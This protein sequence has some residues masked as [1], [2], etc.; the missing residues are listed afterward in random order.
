MTVKEETIDDARAAVALAAQ[1]PEIDGKRI[2]V[3]GHSLGGYLAP[4]IA[5]G[6]AQVTGLIILAGNTRPMEDLI[7]EQL[8]AQAAATPKPPE[9]LTKAIAAAEATKRE[10]EDP[11]LKAGT[12]VKVLGMDVPASYFL[13]LRGYRPAETAA[14][15]AIPMLVLQ[16]ERDAQV[17]MA[18]FEGWKKALATRH[19]VTFKTYPTLNHLF[20]VS[21]GQSAQE[22]Y[23]TPSH[24]AQDVITDVAAW[25]LE[26]AGERSSKK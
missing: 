14:S 2:V 22:E 7:I 18:D 25:V 12:S 8:R 10:V 15:L 11:N 3:L 16:G 6:D 4:R 9:E 17:K 13:D 19:D 5:K 20:M 1:T 26:A 24:V 23:M 21:S